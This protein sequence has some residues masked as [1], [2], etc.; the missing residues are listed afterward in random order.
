M[1]VGWRPEDEMAKVAY[2]LKQLSITG[3]HR[4]QPNALTRDY[5]KL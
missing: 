3:F 4:Q 2:Q 5:R 1:L